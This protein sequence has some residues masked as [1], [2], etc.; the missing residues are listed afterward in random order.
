MA[1]TNNKAM[2]V[3]MPREDNQNPVWDL[4]SVVPGMVKTTVKAIDPVPQQTYY[5]GGKRLFGGNR[6]RTP[7]RDTDTGK[8]YKSKSA[9]GR[10]LCTEAGTDSNDHFAWYKLLAKFPSRF[11][12]LTDDEYLDS[13]IP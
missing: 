11:E 1:G 9:C 12:E 2:T 4:S 8:V 5:G 13:L 6:A 10:A 7:I 3:F